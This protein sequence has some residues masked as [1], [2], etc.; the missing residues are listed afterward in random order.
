MILLRCETIQT[1][2]TSSTCLNNGTCF[3]D[4][5]TGNM[6]ARC[7]CSKGYTGKYCEN[8]FEPTTI[9]SPN[10]CGYNGTCIQT[11]N[12]SYYCICSN[13]LTGQSCN[14]STFSS[15]SSSP[16]RYSSTC[17]QIENSNPP[18]YQCICP[19]YLTG[20]RCQYTN[21][22]QKQPCLNQGT[23]IPLGA[24][25]NFMCLCPSGFGHYDCSICKTNVFTRKKKKI[26][27]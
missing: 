25:N 18:R 17:Q 19:D 15:C 1:I 13:G 6:T 2:C 7:L 22:C 11:S 27:S 24:Q 26:I 5:S 23:C 3:I 16:C 4:T 12:S 9:C 8:F 21:T 10:P 14:S 20:D